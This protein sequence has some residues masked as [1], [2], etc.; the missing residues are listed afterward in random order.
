MGATETELAV[1]RAELKA[2]R[3][4]TD[5]RFAAGEKALQLQAAEYD[6]R[7]AALNGEAERLRQMQVSFV[8]REVYEKLSQSQ[9]ALAAV[10]IE[11]VLK[12]EGLA[13]SNKQ[14][15]G[16]LSAGNMWLTRLVIGT[17][18]TALILGGVALVFQMIGKHP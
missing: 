11:R 8:P 9:S 1:L 4:Q 10:N 18:L 14:N 15:L 12:L 2:L 7:L 5:L 13:E 6:R 16:V 3:E 17:F